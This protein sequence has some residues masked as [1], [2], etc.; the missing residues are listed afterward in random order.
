MVTFI[1]SLHSLFN[2][3]VLCRTV[4]RHPA[5]GLENEAKGRFKYFLLGKKGEVQ[6][7]N[8]FGSHAVKHIPPA[9]MRSYNYHTFKR[10]HLSYRFPAGKP[11]KK[12]R[13][14]FH[15]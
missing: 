13:Q 5:H 12:L 6:L 2:Q 10:R 4:N 3:I 7:K 15:G 14:Q 9:G 8:E 1:K 11:E